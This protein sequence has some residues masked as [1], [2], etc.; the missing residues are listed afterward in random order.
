ML[1]VVL[2][3]ADADGRVDEL[4]DHLATEWTVAP[5]LP[6]QGKAAYAALLAEADAVVAMS[7]PADGPPAPRL[8]LLQ[9]PGAGFDGID[10]ASVP[11]DTW[12]CNVFEHEIGIAEYLLAAMLEWQIGLR[13]M[14]RQIRAGD[15]Q[16]TFNHP[17]GVVLHGELNGKTVGLIGYGHIGQAVAARA[18]SFGCRVIACT[19]SPAK[20]KDDPHAAAVWGMDALPRLL[21]EADFV[22]VACPL[23]TETQGLIGQA[24]LAA[25]KDTGVI[26]NVARGP[27]IQEQALFD[28][29]AGR[30]IG[31][32]IVDVWY[33]YPE[34]GQT[35]RLPS[36]LPFHELDN[37]I[38]SPHASGLSEGL[39][40][41]RWRTIAGNL[42]AV[43]RG[44]EPA[45]VLRR[46]GETSLV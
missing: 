17:D 12:V 7:W 18:H 20:A 5:W 32:A 43:A 22:I 34:A 3:G 26:A 37:I 46:P 31:G 8:K 30:H 41:R 2:R 10:F 27:V 16:G 42:D 39:L 19:R 44:D 6:A 33:R 40:Q 14:D 36:D 29:L 13:R 23:T 9:L 28:S 25:M 38:M 21:A 45:N 4:R 24:E 35:A 1:K 15:W 11:A